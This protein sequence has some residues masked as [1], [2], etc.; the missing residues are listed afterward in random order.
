MSMSAELRP[1]AP[2]GLGDIRESFRCWPLW[3]TLGRYDFRLQHRR[4]TLGPLWLTFQAAVWITG[5]TIIFGR[6]LHRNDPDTVT[7]ITAGLV[8]WNLIAAAFSEGVQTFSHRAEILR[9]VNIPL[10]TLALRKLVVLL[11]RFGW[12]FPLIP[13]VLIILAASGQPVLWPSLWVVPG[14][15]LLIMNLSWLILLMG[16][17]GCRFRD[18][19]YLVSSAMRFLFFLSPVFWKPEAIGNDRSFLATFNPLTYALEIVRAPLLGHPPSATAWGV[20]LMALVLGGSLSLLLF[21]RY[22]NALVFWI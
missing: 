11:C 5:L 2:S 15:I 22:R 1:P 17:L 21:R 18:T 12:Q 19:S 16:L 4:A 9:S 7:Y 10:M 20:G 14:L 13:L 8:L 3:L 6:T